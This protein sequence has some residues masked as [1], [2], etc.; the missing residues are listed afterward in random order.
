MK[1]GKRTI[2]GILALVILLGLSANALALQGGNITQYI[3]AYVNGA[4]NL[5][6][7][8]DIVTLSDS[9]IAYAIEPAKV[10]TRNDAAYETY[11]EANEQLKTGIEIIM[12]YGYPLNNG[13]NGETLDEDTGIAADKARYATAIAIQAW[14]IHNGA[15]A[16]E[17]WSD[18]VSTPSALIASEGCESVVSYIRYLLD[19]ASSQIPIPHGVT[20]IGGNGTSLTNIK[21]KQTGSGY[22]AGF[23]VKLQNLD[24]GYVLD[25]SSMP[26]GT[27]ADGY[28][29]YDGDNVTIKL[30]ADCADTYTISLKGK[31]SRIP[32]NYTF[33]TCTNQDDT[34]KLV[35]MTMTTPYNTEEVA[36]ATVQINKNSGDEWSFASPVTEQPAPSAPLANGSFPPVDGS[37]VVYDY[38]TGTVIQGA[39]LSINNAAG[40]AVKQAQTDA[41]GCVS[42]TDLPAGKYTVNQTTAAQGYTPDSNSYKFGVIKTT[43]STLYRGNTVIVN[44][45]KRV[46]IIVKNGDTPLS[47]MSFILKSST[48]QSSSTTTDANGQGV[49]SGLQNGTYNIEFS[50]AA[51]GTPKDQLEALKKLSREIFITDE[52]DNSTAVYTF[53][54]AELIG[55]RKAKTGEAEVLLALRFVFFVSVVFVACYALCRIVDSSRRY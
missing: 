41:T 17:G 51:E 11:I 54:I 27:Q 44:Q 2:S 6:L 14:A 21:M 4:G 34:S 45:S 1:K 47:G 7:K 8:P 18:F 26:Q 10:S 33:Y 13:M 43:S 53:N 19:K 28:T 12:Q 48:G 37:I 42:I 50:S 55:N 40:T 3:Q 5:P 49:F 23:T 52:H 29:G 36:E 32:S 15:T 30:S 38:D 22:E 25:L 31:D 9:T 35:A 46:T 24:K 16:P 20:T 39:G